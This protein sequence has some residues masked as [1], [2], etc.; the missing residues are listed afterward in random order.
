MQFVNIE[1]LTVIKNITPE[2]YFGDMKA[3][4]GVVNELIG[5][6]LEEKGKIDIDA[7]TLV[8]VIRRNNDLIVSVDDM[9]S[10][11]YYK[12]QKLEGWY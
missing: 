5:D 7:G 2:Q 12:E 4:E 11:K 10:N 1:D 8:R 3:I 9:I 6:I